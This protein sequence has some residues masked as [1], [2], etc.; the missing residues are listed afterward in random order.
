MSRRN[1]WSG[2]ETMEMLEIIK[3]KN[4]MELFTMNSRSMKADCDVY[5]IIEDEMKQNGFRLKDSC[6]IYHKWKNLKRAF[7]ISRKCNQGT[8]NCEF[9]REL[10]DILEQQCVTSR[11]VLEQRRKQKDP[12][13]LKEG[14]P[15]PTRRRR[16]PPPKTIRNQILDKLARMMKDQS[17]EYAKKWNDLYDYE[18][19]LYKRKEKEQAASLNALLEASKTDVMNR[20]ESMFTEEPLTG[21][22]DNGQG[23]EVETIEPAATTSGG[24]TR[25]YQT[26]KFE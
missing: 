21:D 9:A 19:K 22:G 17:E 3:E 1:V 16:G 15:A 26:V 24:A 13:V 8:A 12:T 14:Q 25:V 2:E 10:K 18:F 23:L 20:F 4:L 11:E 6:Q 7:Y 5:K